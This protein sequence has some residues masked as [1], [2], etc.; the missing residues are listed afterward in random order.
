MK[1]SFLKTWVA[2]AMAV[3]VASCGG[4]GGGTTPKSEQ[5][6]SGFSV[7]PDKVK[8]G[9]VAVAA[10]SAT[11]NLPVAFRSSTPATCTTSGIYGQDV[12]GI[13]VGTC[14]VT[15]SQAGND[16]FSSAAEQSVNITVDPIVFDATADF[17]G[18]EN[19]NGVWSYGWMP[20]DFSL[21]SAFTTSI[22]VDWWALWCWSSSGCASG[23][24]PVIAKN[25]SGNVTHVGIP[26]GKV[27]LHP[28]PGYEPSVLRWTA[29][30]G[31]RFRV[32]GQ[33]LPG[34]INSNILV[35]VRHADN[36]LWQG[37]DAGAFN[38]DV[39]LNAGSEVDFTA[40]GSYHY[41]NTPIELTITA[42]ELQN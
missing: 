8:L 37:V 17:S 14:M 27:S 1:N 36:W 9:S 6:I 10:A 13:A 15:A 28:G 35:G 2:C 19:P 39:P 16:R 30:F 24:P 25:S 41:G 26:P 20:T 33:F 21:F 29:P 40:Y 18:T 7:S 5:S 3:V 42:Y 4:G 34:D 12:R 22:E 38:L 32:T 31:G 11:S 23:I